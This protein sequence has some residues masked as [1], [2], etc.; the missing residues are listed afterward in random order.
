MLS[1]NRCPLI[2]CFLVLRDNGVKVSVSIVA[3]VKWLSVVS[4]YSD[5]CEDAALRVRGIK[6]TA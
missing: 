2:C 1:Y 6:A 3:G 5:G 4:G